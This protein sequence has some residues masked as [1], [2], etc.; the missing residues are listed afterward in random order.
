MGDIKNKKAQ[1]ILP[2]LLFAAMAAAG[3]WYIAVIEPGRSILPGCVLYEFTG[4]YCTGCGMTRALHFLLHGQF[5]QAFRMNPLAMAASPFLIVFIGNMLYRT[6]KG[7]PLPN[8]PSWVPW[9]ALVV[10]VAYTVARNL[11]WAPFSWL[12]PTAVQWVWQ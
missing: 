1:V 3:L 4:L 7:N 2:A 10:I 6:F 11:P 8:M 12:A 5:Y 9:V